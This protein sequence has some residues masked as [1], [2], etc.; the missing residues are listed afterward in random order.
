MCL[1]KR[2]LWTLKDFFIPLKIFKIQVKASVLLASCG[3]F[4]K[5]ATEHGDRKQNYSHFYYR[6][7][8]LKQKKSKICITIDG[9]AFSSRVF[10]REV[11]YLQH[12]A[13]LE[14]IRIG[15]RKKNTLLELRNLWQA[16]TIIQVH[17]TLL[18]CY[19]LYLILLKFD[20]GNN[21]D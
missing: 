13:Q 20:Q 9:A 21:N 7:W 6:V 2:V 15:R 8:N 10:C 3:L 4:G 18:T 19:G 11:L 1:L 14:S 16:Y 17:N 12:V 5:S